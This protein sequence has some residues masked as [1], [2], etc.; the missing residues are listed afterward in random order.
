MNKTMLALLAVL[1]PTASTLR[2]AT[3][4]WSANANGPVWSTASNWG[5][6]EPGTTDIAQFAS[7]SYNSQPSLTS[8]AAVGGVWDTGAGNV[9]IGG[10]SALTIF[11]TTINGNNG[12]GIE[13]EDGAGSMTINVPLVLLNDQQW[14]NNSTSELAIC[15]NISGSGS[16]TEI[17]S[18]LL[19]LSGSN[20]VGRNLTVNGGSLQL[21]GGSFALNANGFEN[22]GGSGTGCFTQSAG[23]NSLSTMGALR[24]GNNP[25][26][27]GTYI[28]SGSGL[29]ACA[30]TY[31][32]FASQEYVGY[33]GTGSFTQSGGTNIVSANYL[34]KNGLILGYNSPSYGSYTLGNAG[35]LTTFGEYIGYR[36]TG[37]FTQSGGTNN[38]SV[39]YG[40]DGNF[41]NENSLYVGYFSS[42][43][44]TLSNSGLLTAPGEYIGYSGMGSFTQSG[45]TNNIGP[46]GLYL[47]YGG[48]G[49][50]TL[51]SSGL[52]TGS[53][54][55]IGYGNFTQ[56]GGTNTTG[57]LSI[58]SAGRYQWGG[59]ALQVAGG[60][61]NQGVFDGGGGTSSLCGS[62]WIVDFSHGTL[63]NVGSMSLAL[64][65]N[66]LLIVPTGF[67]PGS[68]FASYS[69]SGMIHTAGTPLTVLARQGFAGWGTIFDHVN[70][71]GTIIATAGGAINLAN[72]LS[73]SGSGHVDLGS[74]ALTFNDSSSGMNSGA[75]FAATETAGTGT[76]TQTGGT[77]TISGELYFVEYPAAF[78]GTYN[79]VGGLLVAPYINGLG[80]FN[81]AGGSLQITPLPPNAIVSL[82]NPTVLNLSGTLTMLCNE[83]T[84]FSNPVAGAG[85]LIYAG[86]S[87]LELNGF[88][89]RNVY[90]GGTFVEGGTLI[91]DFAY[92]LPDG[93]SLTIGANAMSIFGAPTVDAS[94]VASAAPSPSPVPEPGT[95]TF[96]FA[97]GLI[98]CVRLRRKGLSHQGRKTGGIE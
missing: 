39:D 84:S 76:F 12:T 81:I 48:S 7:D 1:C 41:L 29:L 27:S 36:G 34:G 46:D 82:A 23:T 93:S 67:N 74:G 95:L 63:Q 16:L 20:S 59:G 8:T 45:G 56:S 73:L 72:G 52:L 75:L 22:I 70:C 58:G 5:G 30:S 28:L 49:T 15:G 53:A 87:T 62:S 10:T 26:S 4:S 66:S 98:I 11:G 14:V 21:P 88:N 38:V 6:T 25:G 2:A 61:A 37:S 40:V 9:T 50:Y 68:L 77:N 31:S 97:A 55:Y 18:G 54:E 43:T 71:Q 19:T 91:V 3:F 33:S 92:S 24:L 32:A 80:K 44:Y 65:P 96:L 57:F 60:I 90:T 17:G 83:S 69:N 79:L 85:G 89:V 13:M 94:P 86:P 47:G 42:G 51:S 78:A 35:L 64:G